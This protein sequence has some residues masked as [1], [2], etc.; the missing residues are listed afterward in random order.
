[1][2]ESNIKPG[3]YRATIGH[4]WRPPGEEGLKQYNKWC[5]EHNRKPEEGR[6]IPVNELLDHV[7]YLHDLYITEDGRDL[8]HFYDS[9]E[10]FLRMWHIGGYD[11][12]GLKQRGSILNPHCKG[13]ELQYV[14][15]DENDPFFEIAYTKEQGGR[16]QEKIWKGISDMGSLQGIVLATDL[17][18]I[19]DISGYMALAINDFNNKRVLTYKPKEETSQKNQEK[20]KYYGLSEDEDPYIWDKGREFPFSSLNPLKTANHTWSVIG[21]SPDDVYD[22]FRKLGFTFPENSNPKI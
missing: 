20:W 6:L 8:P 4:P 18:G 16:S 9:P 19:I 21:F 7:L 12:V 5:Q 1:M 14:T 10:Q 15:W 13:F 22:I 3:I 11:D 2:P 17:N